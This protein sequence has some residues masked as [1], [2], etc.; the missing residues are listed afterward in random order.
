MWFVG[1]L[2]G[3]IH[4]PSWTQSN[5][6]CAC[7]FHP[8]ICGV[9]RTSWKRLVCRETNQS[10]VP[11]PSSAPVLPPCLCE[12]Q[13]FHSYFP[14]TV[15]SAFVTCI[16]SLLVLCSRVQR[17]QLLLHPVIWTNKLREIKLCTLY[18]HLLCCSGRH[19]MDLSKFDLPWV[20][21]HYYECVAI[22]EHHY[23]KEKQLK[24][25]F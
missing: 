7:L 3:A 25:C 22:K 16:V 8:N 11:V 18:G 17:K 2:K 14:S 9:Q 1:A 10:E 6:N 24:S 15:G 4:G 13:A 20:A 19:I 12:T 5:P 21:P 23:A